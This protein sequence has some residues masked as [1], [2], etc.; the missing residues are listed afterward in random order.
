MLWRGLSQAAVVVVVVVGR[1]AAA[2]RTG[3]C[4]RWRLLSLC[5]CPST[6][7]LRRLRCWGQRR[8]LRYARAMCVYN[9]RSL[10]ASAVTGGWEGSTLGTLPQNSCF[11]VIYIFIVI[12]AQ[13]KNPGAAAAAAAAPAPGAADAAAKHARAVLFFAPVDQHHCCCRWRCRRRFVCRWR[14][15]RGAGWRCCWRWWAA[16]GEKIP[17]FVRKHVESVVTAQH[18]HRARRRC[19]PG[20][21][22]LRG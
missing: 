11:F 5:S 22:S 21:I 8:P 15:R 10:T 9:N 1:A 12:C 4:L 20:T 7:N 18:S 17:R 6:P 16:N 14:R 19:R 13:P 3:S 2:A